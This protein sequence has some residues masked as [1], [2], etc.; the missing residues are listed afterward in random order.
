MFLFCIQVNSLKEFQ[1]VVQATRECIPHLESTVEK[2][3]SK[4]EFS[5]VDLYQ[6]D[7][8]EELKSVGD[9]FF[10]KELHRFTRYFVSYNDGK[11]I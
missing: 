6:N 1:E 2:H 8:N 3:Y 5:L 7:R 10:S 4:T 11:H 9:I